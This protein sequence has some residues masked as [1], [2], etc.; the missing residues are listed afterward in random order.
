VVAWKESGGNNG[1]F[2]P[3]A[4]FL[5]MV[6]RLDPG[7]HVVKLVWKANRADAGTIYAGAGASPP[8]SPTRL[9]VVLVPTTVPQ[10]LSSAAITTQ[11]ILS[12]SNAT[13]WAP[14]GVS[15]QPFTPVVDGTAVVI[16]NADLWTANAGYNQDMGIAV[17]GS[18]VA[19]KE[20]VGSG[21]T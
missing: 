15:L 11:P 1:T 19:W 6:T 21:G 10:N 3:N 16:G 9:T 7:S 17:N 12:N 5:H 13:S 2:S 8:F 14:M 20:S 18:V 4:A